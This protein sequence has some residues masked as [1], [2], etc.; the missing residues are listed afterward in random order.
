M[1]WLL[2]RSEQDKKK[3]RGGSVLLSNIQTGEK[4][5]TYYIV[6]LFQTAH[7]KKRWTNTRHAGWTDVKW[8]KLAAQRILEAVPDCFG[9]KS[10]RET[11]VDEAGNE[12]NFNP[13][14]HCELNCIEYYCAALKRY[15]RKN[16]SY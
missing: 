6:A 10:L 9:E 2:H 14:F 8:A 7:T 16:C 12:V 4:A 1:R 13:K 15:I 5:F 11:L 3:G